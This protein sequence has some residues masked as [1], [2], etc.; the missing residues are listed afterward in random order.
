MVSQMHRRFHIL[1]R[2]ALITLLV[3]LI[4]TM[5]PSLG[6]SSTSAFVG[7]SFLCGGP[8][9]ILYWAAWVSRRRWLQIFCACCA[10][11]IAALNLLC[12]VLSAGIVIIFLSIYAFILAVAVGAI[13]LSLR[14]IGGVPSASIELKQTIDLVQSTKS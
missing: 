1:F 6:N 14:L 12:L 13:A 11:P 9:A 3:A 7:T 4:V 10:I 8:V 5:F 2:I